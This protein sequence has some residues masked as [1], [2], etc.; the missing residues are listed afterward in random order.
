MNEWAK[1]T[2][3]RRPQPLRR[4]WH[5]CDKGSRLSSSGKKRGE[6]SFSRFVQQSL[7]RFIFSEQLKIPEV[8][9]MQAYAALAPDRLLTHHVRE[10]LPVLVAA[11]VPLAPAVSKNAPEGNRQRV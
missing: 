2:L 8:W 3:H 1:S 5:T 9:A 7:K 11:F 10:R 6:T 4:S